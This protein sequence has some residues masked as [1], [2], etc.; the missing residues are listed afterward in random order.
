MSNSGQDKVTVRVEVVIEAGQAS[1]VEAHSLAGPIHRSDDITAPQPC[2]RDTPIV[3]QMGGKNYIEAWGGSPTINGKLPW[4]VWALAYPMTGVSTA[5]HPKPDT[6]AISTTPTATGQWSFLKADN[7]AVPN[8]NCDK[9]PCSSGGSNNSTLLIWWD[10]GTP[11][12]PSYA[13]VE[14]RPFH[15]YCPGSGVAGRGATAG[16]VAVGSHH[17]A[18]TL[19]ATF[20][21][22]LAKLGTV[23]LTWNGVSWAGESSVGGGSVLSFLCHDETFQLMAAGPGAAFIVA[24]LPKTC[25]PFYWT[26]E[27]KAHG[28]LNGPFGVTIVE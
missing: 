11:S 20:T 18:T 17:L 26:A 25:Q 22:A 6:G 4:K 2:P 9:T 5:M 19:R 14:S 7:K 3:L 15:G 27:G 12:A 8:A 16:A 13:N 28:A 21:G 10:Y 1:S 23:G 24:G